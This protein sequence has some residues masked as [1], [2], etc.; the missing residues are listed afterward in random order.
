LA[1]STLAC[2]TDIDKPQLGLQKSQLTILVGQF[3]NK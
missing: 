3:L 2:S 1:L